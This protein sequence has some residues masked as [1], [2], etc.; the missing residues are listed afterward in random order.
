V[1]RAEPSV[2]TYGDLALIEAALAFLLVDGGHK[3]VA[4]SVGGIAACNLILSVATIFRSKRE[5]P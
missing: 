5:G 2:L 1:S 4:C 3:F